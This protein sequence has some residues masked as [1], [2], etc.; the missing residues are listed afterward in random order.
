MNRCARAERWSIVIKISKH[1]LIY[2]V[3]I[4]IFIAASAAIFLR[5][6][7]LIEKDLYKSMADSAEDIAV[8][9]ANS[10]PISDAE[11]ARL[12][13][14]DYMDMLKDP[15]YLRFSNMATKIFIKNNVRIVCIMT[16][17]APKEIR[18]F[19]KPEDQKF[20]GA[21]VGTP[22]DV[23]WLE[24]YFFPQNQMTQQQYETWKEDYFQ[25]F[26]RYSFARP[27]QKIIFDNKRRGN[28]IIADEWGHFIVGFAPLYTTEGTFVGTV[29]VDFDIAEYAARWRDIYYKI[30]G[31]FC[32]TFSLLLCTVLYIYHQYSM[33]D[34]RAKY[35]DALT[36]IRNRRYEMEKFA[37]IKTLV[38]R[39]GVPYAAVVMLDLDHFKAINDTYGHQTGD[40][41]LRA[42]TNS[43]RETLKNTPNV[44]LRWGGEEFVAVAPCENKEDLKEML[45]RLIAGIRDIKA[46]K[47]EA[48]STDSC[49]AAS[50]RFTVSAGGA[51]CPC[52][53]M[54]E[55]DL[56]NAITAA[57]KL[58]YKAK[59]EGR[60]RC[61]V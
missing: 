44:L 49:E 41:C 52:G 60:D 51:L 32:A 33:A 30:I 36:G 47:P 15:A 1:A 37:S 20:Y 10:Y 31:A 11:F 26:K 34:D 14:I 45:E 43:C 53:T 4:S 40:A 12:K 54:T 24:D 58:M 2:G 29:N 50:V 35:T 46:D 8:S 61:C 13:K 21:P 5:S 28:D 25:D 19:V 27:S 9:I 22:L 55:K 56:E 6:S 16:P 18:H 57:D 7:R 3:I 23:I 59:A 38:C 42:F 48:S 39:A 17:L